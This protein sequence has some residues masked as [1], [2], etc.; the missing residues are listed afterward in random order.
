MVVAFWRIGLAYPGTGQ[1]FNPVL[2]T[3]KGQDMPPDCR[4][5]DRLDMRTRVDAREV[6]SPNLQTFGFLAAVQFQSLLQDVSFID[7]SGGYLRARNRDLCTTR[8]CFGSRGTSM[9]RPR[10]VADGESGWAAGGTGAAY[11]A[12]RTACANATARTASPR[13]RNRLQVVG[14]TPGDD[15]GAPET[16][17]NVPGRRSRTSR[18]SQGPVA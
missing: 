4:S 7:V 9:T 17:N 3:R 16:W 13:A 14:R 10:R 2:L 8:E 1:T 15:A 11:P 6:C 18:A 12:G 5:A